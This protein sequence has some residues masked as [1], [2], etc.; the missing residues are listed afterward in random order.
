MRLNG[1]Q[2]IDLKPASKTQ[3]VFITDD[4]LL[5]RW[6]KGDRGFIDG[7][8]TSDGIP[9]I[10]VINE[11]NGIPTLVTFESNVVTSNKYKINGGKKIIFH[12]GCHGCTQQQEQPNGVEFCVDCQNFEANWGVK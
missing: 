12:G 9:M 10:V 5:A 7:Y 1:I 3:V 11:K 2:T 8:V 4:T 6:K